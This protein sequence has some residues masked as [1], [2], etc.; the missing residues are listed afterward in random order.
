MLNVSCNFCF[1]WGQ[2]QDYDENSNANDQNSSSNSKQE[3]GFNDVGLQLEKPLSP[4]IIP[5]HSDDASHL[6]VSCSFQTEFIMR[7]LKSNFFN[8]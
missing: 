1:L 8:L 2:I 4:E 3:N 6:E 5:N 7:Y